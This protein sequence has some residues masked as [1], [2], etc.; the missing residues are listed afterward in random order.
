MSSPLQRSMKLL[1]ADGWV[2]EKVEM[3]NAFSKTRKDLFN[4][5]DLMCVHPTTK[6]TLGVQVT[7]MGQK[8]PHIRKMQ[9]NK[10]LPIVQR[11]GWGVQLHSWRKLKK[12]GWTVDIKVFE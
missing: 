11:A 8:Q 4:L 12:T 3:W 7:T 5:F 2:V 1:R 10:I 6:A 9:A